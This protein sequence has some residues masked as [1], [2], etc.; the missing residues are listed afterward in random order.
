MGSSGT[1]SAMP[2]RNTNWLTVK[3]TNG[4][5]WRSVP[6]CP[7][8]VSTNPRRLATISCGGSLMLLEKITL[9]SAP[10]AEPMNTTW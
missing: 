5:F 3:L 8:K 7:R 10:T 6:L 1:A 9:I 2:Q 4:R